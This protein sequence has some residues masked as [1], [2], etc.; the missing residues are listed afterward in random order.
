[1]NLVQVA[2]SAA[3]RFGVNH[4]RFVHANFVDFDCGSFDGLYLFNP[5][6]EQVKDDPF[7]IDEVLERSRTLYK[8]YLASTSAQLIRA[9][10]GTL[11]VTYNGF[12]AAM[13]RQY[14]R[15]HREVMGGAELVLWRRG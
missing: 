6:Q 8:T 1:L 10:I 14:G 15:L 3:L 12:G 11:V 7:R 4:T 13:P 2:E 5:F 9:P